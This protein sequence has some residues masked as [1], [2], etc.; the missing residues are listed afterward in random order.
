[1][2]ASDAVLALPPGQPWRASY[3]CSSK[4]GLQVG[5]GFG[6][7][8]PPHTQVT[9]SANVLDTSHPLAASHTP[10]YTKPM[11]TRCDAGDVQGQQRL[12][13]LEQVRLDGGLNLRA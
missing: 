9:A 12:R 3:G 7:H 4:D 1:M 6:K 5:H 2:T 10:E 13:P 11:R 8:H